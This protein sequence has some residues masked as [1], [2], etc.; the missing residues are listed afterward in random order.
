[1]YLT[2]KN[3]ENCSIG[4][5]SIPEVQNFSIFQLFMIALATKV[6]S[7][8]LKF[9]KSSAQTL[10]SRYNAETGAIRPK[11]K[12]VLRKFMAVWHLFYGSRSSCLQQ[13]LSEDFFLWRGRGKGQLQNHII[14]FSDKCCCKPAEE[15]EKLSCFD[16]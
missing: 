8:Y 5:S 14:S 7:N 1:M 15:P 6:T 12:K 9:V 4:N 13:Y 11:I 10:A 3:C 16:S 2:L